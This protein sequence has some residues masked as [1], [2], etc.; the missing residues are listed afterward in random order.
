MGAVLSAVGRT[1]ATVWC[2]RRVG[3]CNLVIG[4]ITF[5]C[6]VFSRTSYVTHWDNE[7]INNMKCMI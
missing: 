6:H 4:R 2:R 3:L 5:V 1:Q 7:G